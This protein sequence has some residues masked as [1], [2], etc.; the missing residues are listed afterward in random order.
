METPSLDAQLLLA[1]ALG[2]NRL[3]LHA[4]PQEPLAAERQIRFQELLSRREAR[5]PLPYLLGEWEFM[6][7]PFR[8]TPAVLIPRPETEILVEAAAERLPENAEVLDVG[9]GT[10]CIAVALAKRLRAG[11]VIALEASLEA[12]EVARQNVRM[13][14]AAGSVEVREGFFPVAARDL[15]PLDAVVSNPPYIPSAEVESLEP[16]LRRW[17]PRLA[18]DGGPDGLDVIRALAVESPG[19]LKENGLLAVEVALGQAEEVAALLRAAGA[20]QEPQV[21]PDLGGV[22]RVVLARKR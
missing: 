20:W 22:P 13:L 15:G 16:E 17:E 11:R 19:L 8:V 18:L 14:E 12:A 3:Y 10:G 9:A 7:M 4:H 21:L 5:E 2:Q 1:H 6:G